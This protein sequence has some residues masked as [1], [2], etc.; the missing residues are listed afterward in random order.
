MGVTFLEHQIVNYDPSEKRKVY[1]I[2]RT[3]VAEVHLGWDVPRIE[4]T[5][6]QEGTEV[7]FGAER[8]LVI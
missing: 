2:S 6:L 5:I 8:R 1:L 4:E 7:K 3:H